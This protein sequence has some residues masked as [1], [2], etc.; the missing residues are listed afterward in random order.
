MT[1]LAS[2]EGDYLHRNRV[3][4]FHRDWVNEC[5]FCLC[6]YAFAPSF[7]WHYL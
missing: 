6:Y 3:E 1:H 2:L 4:E 5:V 7:K